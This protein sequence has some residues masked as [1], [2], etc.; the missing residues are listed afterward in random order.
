MSTL[1]NQEAVFCTESTKRLRHEPTSLER[2][3]CCGHLVPVS[4]K[5]PTPTLEHLDGHH[6]KPIKQESMYYPS[7]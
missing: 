1:K 4:L 3:P 6:T 5:C 7:C 2:F